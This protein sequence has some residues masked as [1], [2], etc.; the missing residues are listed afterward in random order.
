MAERTVRTTRLLLR[1]LLPTDEVAVMSYRG[2][3]RAGRFL[4]HPPL[5][6]GEYESWR[7]ER[8]AE[9]AFEHPGDRRFWGVVVTA[10]QRLVG[11]AVLVRSEDGAAAELGMFLHPDTAGLGYAV[12]AGVALIETAF[13]DLGMSRVLAR[14]DPRNIAS[15]RGLQRLGLRLVQQDAEVV[16]ACLDA[17]EWASAARP[18]PP[19]RGAAQPRAA[20][21]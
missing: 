13:R 4:R 18:S 5:R 1:P 11:D 20:R 12:E 10:T 19:V 9:W 15:I 3:P 14:A 7:A 21:T 17:E 16:L 6:P 8:S 2:D